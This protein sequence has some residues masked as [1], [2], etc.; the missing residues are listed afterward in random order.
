MIYT[1]EE[2]I[3][4]IIPPAEKYNVK[5]M[6]L[7]GSYAKGE[8]TDNS[9]IDILAETGLKGIKFYGLLEALTEALDKDV[10]LIDIRDVSD[11]KPLLDEIRKTGVLLYEQERQRDIA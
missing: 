1:I 2:I 5:K 3:E 9:D 8:A 11:N 4:R 7:F 6:Y 10:D